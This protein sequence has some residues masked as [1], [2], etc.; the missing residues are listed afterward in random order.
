MRVAILYNPRPECSS[1]ALDDAF[2]EYDEP[3]TIIAIAKALAGMGVDPT[4]I[5]AD[6]EVAE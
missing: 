6:A 4:P 1:G 3:Q 5:T 2:E